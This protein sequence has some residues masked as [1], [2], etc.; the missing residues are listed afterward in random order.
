MTR[1]VTK[2]MARLDTLCM[3]DVL[4]LVVDG[5]D[6]FFNDVSEAGLDMS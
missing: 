3:Q 6:L 1:I 5:L 2:L 4:Y